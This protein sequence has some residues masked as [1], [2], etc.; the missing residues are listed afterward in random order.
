[1]TGDAR[2]FD[3]LHQL[4]E[5]QAYRL[6]YWRVAGE[7]I[8][9]RRFFDIH[10]LA[11]VRAEDQIV[12][13]AIHRAVLSWVDDGGIT[14][15]RID[16]PDGLADPL[17]YIQRLQE[18]I[19][20]RTCRRRFEREW[21]NPSAPEDWPAVAERLRAR[22]RAELA[23]DPASPIARFFP[24]VAEKILSKGEDLPDDWPL[25][26]TVGYEYLN[27]LNGLFI[28]ADARDAI[29]RI[30]DDFTGDRTPFAEVLH[31][32]K[33]LITRRILASE[34]NTLT[35]HLDKIASHDRRNRDFTLNTLRHALREVIAA[36]PIYRT[37]LQPGAAVSP[38]D[39][40]YI[41][42]AVDEARRRN[43]T[44]DGSLF[45]FLQTVLTLDHPGDL[46]HDQRKE[47]E[48]FVVRFQQTTG[49][50]QAKGLEDTAFYRQF[51]LASINEVGADPTRFGTAPA[52]FHAMNLKRLMRW[53]GALATTTT[54]DTKRGEDARLRIDA[55]S[56]LPDEWSRHLSRW[57]ELHAPCRIDL[58][59]RIAP[60]GCEQYSA[61][62]NPPGAWPW[63][64][65]DL[66][67]TPPPG[68]VA[69]IQGYL[70]KAAR[71]A[72]RNTNWTD[73][74]LS[75]AQA[76]EQF[77]A[78]VLEG[79]TTAA[80][81]DDFLPFVRRLA[82]IA[83]VHSLSQT[84]L[85]LASPGVPDIYQGSELWDLR[86]VDPDNRQPVD[87][88]RRQ[89]LL[90]SLCHS[91]ESGR[92]RAELARSLREHPE[93]GAI[94]LYVIATTLNHRRDDPELYARGDYVHLN[95]QGPRKQHLVAFARIGHDR[96]VVVVAAR[97]SAPLMG[98]DAATLPVGP[99]VWGD[100][101][102][103]LPE[104]LRSFRWRDL[105]TGALS[106]NQPADGQVALGA[107]KTLGFLP[108]ALLAA[109]SEV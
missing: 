92:P 36:F 66:A 68:F 64:E 75:Y 71:E 33:T 43:P 40:D 93:D 103:L 50:V 48:G 44:M 90:K 61:L 59:G 32:S 102:I 37:Y 27:V 85:K 22:Y 100:T 21:Q 101:C 26:G 79:P 18:T 94:K 39:R 6:A 87:F 76:L 106:Q 38:R 41:A 78:R 86:L 15:L 96:A 74:D 5:A 55:L 63:A 105:L 29:R 98:P 34:L 60:D 108:V 51:P 45:D 35:N 53:S 9:Y 42:Q 16:H 10:D 2:S 95:I 62:S 82:R 104:S 54:H 80:F 7:E 89:E 57:A 47:R 83:V 67:P 23:A 52:D 91:S 73:P 81:L 49:P 28:N 19:L 99:E 8:N 31:E 70:V 46:S 65:R 12:F 17:G 25:D 88:D 30:Y 3:A 58:G 97:L 14:G 13:E 109:E 56:E 20:L 24:V 84:L 69:R 4:L 1:M 11:G 107:A 72:K 77:V